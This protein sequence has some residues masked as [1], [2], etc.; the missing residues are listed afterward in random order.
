MVSG[1]SR[2]GRS[3]IRRA[4]VGWAGMYGG[5]G[6]PFITLESQSDRTD[7]EMR[8]RLTNFLDYGRKYF[9]DY[10]RFY[11][12]VAQLHQRGV[13]HFH[14][15]LGQ[16]LPKR[17]ML[18]LRELWCDTYGMG[19]GSFDIKGMRSGKGAAR[20]LAGY[21]TGDLQHSRVGLD[22]EGALVFEPWRVSRH[23]GRPYVRVRFRGNPYRMSEAARYFTRP[24]TQVAAEWGAFPWLYQRHGWAVYFGSLDLAHQALTALVT[25][26]PLD[27]G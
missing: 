6:V 3:F 11:V 5:R 26:P 16:R 22:G 23:N 12:A 27:S 1:P 25:P 14:L 17:L 10:F 18:K 20:Y 7:E 15:V 13:L 2:T 4:I 8:A 19:P 21:L 24:V 9:G